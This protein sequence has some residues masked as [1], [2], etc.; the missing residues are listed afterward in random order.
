MTMWLEV[1]VSCP[2]KGDPAAARGRADRHDAGASTDLGIRGLG[3]AAPRPG[4]QR[5]QRRALEDADVR[6]RREAVAQAPGQPRRLDGRR[7]GIERRPAE[8]RRAAALG[9]L[10]GVE[11]RDGTGLAELMGGPD[12]RAPDIVL[13]RRGRHLQIAGVPEPGVDLLLVAEPADLLNRSGRGAPQGH[14]PLV[15]VAIAHRAHVEPHL[16]AEAAV[17]P[18]RPAPAEVGLD[19]HDIRAG[20]ELREPP[21]RPHPR[22]AAAD[23][24]EVAIDRPLGRRERIADRR[25]GEPVAVCVVAHGVEGCRVSITKKGANAYGR[26][27]TPY[28]RPRRARRRGGGDLPLHPLPAPQAAELDLHRRLHRDGRG[29]ARSTCCSAR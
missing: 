21:G 28:S 18:A 23:H 16:V 27:D 7:A 4:A 5:P 14:R 22:V 12:R 20:L 1:T 10:G 8:P 11:H 15:A 17:P 26:F 6:R 24:E 9:Q 2:R 19:Q 13:G 29:G 3:L 25:L